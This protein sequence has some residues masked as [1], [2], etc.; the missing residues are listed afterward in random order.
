[1]PKRWPAGMNSCLSRPNWLKAGGKKPSNWLSQKMVASH[2][3]SIQ[4]AP[5]LVGPNCAA[6]GSPANL[7]APSVLAQ[8]AQAAKLAGRPI[9][10]NAQLRDLGA[11]YHDVLSPGELRSLWEIAESEFT[12]DGAI[13]PAGW[14][15]WF[16]SSPWHRDPQ[17]KRS[18]RR[19]TNPAGPGIHL[20]RWPGWRQRPA[21][22][23]RPR[24][25]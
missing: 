1:M 12:E 13:Q 14:R 16:R 17:L 6:F 8:P 4:K 9:T 11:K 22:R 3:P 24:A 19:Q 20:S 18:F 23:R 5:T 15:G 10:L 21:A 25:M 7:R 2:R